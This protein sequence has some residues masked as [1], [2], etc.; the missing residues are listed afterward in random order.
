MKMIW[1]QGPGKTAGFGFPDYS[2]EPIQKITTVCSILKYFA[3]FDSPS[4]YVM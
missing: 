3:A 1:D 4:N 2:S